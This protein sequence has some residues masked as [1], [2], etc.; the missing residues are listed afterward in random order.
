MS[1]STPRSASIC[2]RSHLTT[3][4]RRALTAHWRRDQKLISM[5]STMPIGM[6]RM[7][8]LRNS[9]SRPDGR[10][11]RVITVCSRDSEQANGGPVRSLAKL[12]IRLSVRRPCVRVR[13]GCRSW[14]TFTRGDGRAIAAGPRLQSTGRRNGCGNVLK[15]WPRGSHPRGS[16]GTAPSC[17]IDAFECTRP[18]GRYYAESL[19]NVPACEIP[20]TTTRPI[21]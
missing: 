15:R 4:R 5:K 11:R 3:S 21:W 20:I 9:R 8:A 14:H 6:M 10:I 16:S 13:S 2:L 19:P 12:P 17:P 7:R 18:L 1:S